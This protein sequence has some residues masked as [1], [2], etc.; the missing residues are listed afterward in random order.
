MRV[1]LWACMI[2][3]VQRNHDISLKE[4]CSFT[5]NAATLEGKSHIPDWVKEALWALHVNYPTKPH[6]KH[7]INTNTPVS[8]WAYANTAWVCIQFLQWQCRPVNGNQVLTTAVLNLESQMTVS[9]GNILIECDEIDT[10]L[11]LLDSD[12]FKWSS[13]IMHY[14]TWVLFLTQLLHNVKLFVR[15]ILKIVA[16]LSFSVFELQKNTSLLSYIT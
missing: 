2:S 3:D 16:S 4:S 10:I 14:C 9:R 12:N 13:N 11:R 1:S 8:N 15:R 5:L 6:A 7:C